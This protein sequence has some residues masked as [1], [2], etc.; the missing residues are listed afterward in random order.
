M[1]EDEEA[2]KSKRWKIL[3]SMAVI[4]AASMAFAMLLLLVT[5]L[6]PKSMIKDACMESSAYFEENE[7]FPLLV[8]GQFNTR[9]DNYA[10]CIL[11][12]I[13]YIN[14]LKKNQNQ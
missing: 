9:Q 8:D 1:P 10:D 4:T 14:F 12:N 13:M 11:I 3:V 5:G 7:L 2:V 6:I